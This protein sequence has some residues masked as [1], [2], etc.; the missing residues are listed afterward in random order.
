MASSTSELSSF[1]CSICLDDFTDPVS[2]PC[3]HNFCKVCINTYWDSAD[4]V[5][6]PF[7]MQNF[8]KRPH[9]KV[10]VMLRD[11]ISQQKQTNTQVVP[12]A[13]SQTQDIL[14]DVC[15]GGKKAVKSCV[16]CEQSLCSEH[17]KPHQDDAEQ[18]THEL[19]DPVSRLKERWGVLGVNGA[20][21]VR[22]FVHLWRA[23]MHESL[24]WQKTIQ[25]HVHKFISPT[26]CVS[27]TKPLWNWFAIMIW[28]VCVCCAS[29]QIT[30]TISVS[31]WRT[32]WEIKR[33]D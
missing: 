24:L 19:L 8:K 14:C 26:G 33:Y 29:N 30:K 25:V 16:H 27:S 10:N 17:L 3:G 32:A 15:A 23:I 1:K 18:K 20:L 5:Q 11:L 9:L 21:Q 7:C 2:T 31:L 28:L 6:C 22:G 12:E 13:R 4:I